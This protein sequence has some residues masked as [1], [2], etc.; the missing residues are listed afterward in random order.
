[1]SETGPQRLPRTLRRTAPREVRL[2]PQRTTGH[3]LRVESAPLLLVIS[4]LVVILAGTIALSLPLSSSDGEW[5][6]PV[7]ALFVSTSS[8]CVTGLTPVDTGTYWSGFGHGVILVLVQLGGL[9]FMASASLLFLLLGWRLGLRE[10]LFISESL[11]LG[12][13]GGVVRLIRG[14]VLFA[15][16]AEGAGF[17]LLLVRFLP[18]MAV[19]DAAWNA[20][21][22]SVSA[23]NNAGFDV[24]GG[25]SS[26]A[27]HDDPLTLVTIGALALLGGLGFLI[28]A[29]ILRRGRSLTLDTKIV[30]RT[31]A[32]V[33]VA[34]YALF[35]VVEWNAALA[36]FA[37]PDKLLHGLF[38]TVASRTSGFAALST[39]ALQ[40]ESL[41]AM[42]A[43]M[44]IGGASGSTAGGIKLGTLGILLAAAG[45]A[46]A[47]RENVEASGREI[48][49]GDAD[50]AL[51]VAFL[52]VLFVFVTTVLL[53]RLE[54]A[55]FLAILFEATSAFG[56]T[57]LST[58]LTS[59]LRD[60][61]LLVTTVA[62]FAGRLGPLTL[63]LAL[64]ERSR[65]TTRRFPEERVR[66]G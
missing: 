64:I 20:L 12:R 45:A 32:V 43:L 17:V 24:F 37:V 26:L 16:I 3:G 48:R 65:G 14:T 61:S 54:D 33:I 19:A 30:L 55:P 15:F 27:Q 4:F 10:R 25:G 60:E 1:M 22:L 52:S 21:F 38:L 66:I 56:T 5:T 9:G 35:L 31:L 34:G 11:D 2:E 41:F 46:I 58:G 51:A 62:M 29:D 23:F 59:E 47:G 8:V 28:V 44:F 57:G 42:A 7:V 50:R 39:D 18:D 6:S 49:R 63:A 36:G 13:I 40:E 53:A